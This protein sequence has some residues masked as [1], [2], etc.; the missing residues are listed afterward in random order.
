LGQQ[1]AKRDSPPRKGEQTPCSRGEGR[2]QPLERSATKNK[3]RKETPE[4]RTQVSLKGVADGA[5]EK[6]KE[7]E[8]A[9][10]GLEKRI[11]H[12]KVNKG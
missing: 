12:L 8:K 9:K 4:S 5:R 2:R 7:D 6:T 10:K 3:S 1:D 11:I